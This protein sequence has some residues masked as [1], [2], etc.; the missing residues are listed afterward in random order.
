MTVSF[1]LL[2]KQALIKSQYKNSCCRRAIL[3]GSLAAKAEII[4]EREAIINLASSEHTEFISRLVSEFYGQ[5]PEK[6]KSSGGRG[7]CV[8]IT[9][10]SLVK[11]IKSLGEGAPYFTEKCAL[12]QGS[13][14]RGYFLS[15]GRICDPKKQYLLE[16]SP[17]N[18]PEKFLDYLNELGISAKFNRRKCEN[19]IYVKK[20]SIIED[21]FT[22]ASMTSTVFEIMNAKIENEIRNDSNRKRNCDTH[23]I[24]KS[25]VAS[26]EK[27]NVISRLAEHKLLSSLPDDLEQTAR[28]RLENPEMSLQNLARISRPPLSKSG[29][30]HRLN[31]IIEIGS[32]LLRQE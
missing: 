27:I 2:Q 14:L 10:P 22:L 5:I 9:S 15:A 16:F 25:I 13:F 32:Q 26:R 19:V 3:M 17:H 20:S 4:S 12:C 21:F 11:Y 23:N 6:I 28:L 24:D 1:T 30:V 29:L 8:K 31:R 18:E 7:K